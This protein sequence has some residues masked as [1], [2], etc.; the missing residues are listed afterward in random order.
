MT[1]LFFLV[2]VLF[3]VSQTHVATDASV[4]VIAAAATF[5]ESPDFALLEEG[6]REAQR[7]ARPELLASFLA[8]DFLPELGRD[9]LLVAAAPTRGYVWPAVEVVAMQ[10]DRS[11]GVA[12]CMGAVCQRPADLFSAPQCPP[13]WFHSEWRRRGGKWQLSFSRFLHPEAPP[14][15]NYPMIK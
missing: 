12:V 8:V 14:C 11:P 10:C 9:N 2:G 13:K 6:W 5:Q 15:P 4:E 7:R 3:A 1:T